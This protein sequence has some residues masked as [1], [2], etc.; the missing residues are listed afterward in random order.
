MLATIAAKQ[1][2]IPNCIVHRCM[3]NSSVKQAGRYL[4]AII[5]S[6]KSIGSVVFAALHGLGSE[7]SSF[8]LAHLPPNPEIWDFLF[9]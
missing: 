4:H 9:F 6:L 3:M 7:E 8:N 1:M 2:C 5:S